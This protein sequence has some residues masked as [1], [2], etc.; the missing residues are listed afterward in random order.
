[1]ALHS[2]CNHV[3]PL[4]HCPLGARRHVQSSGPVTPAVHVQQAVCQGLWGTGGVV[5]LCIVGIL[6]TGMGGAIANCAVTTFQSVLKGQPQLARQ[7][8]SRSHTQHGEQAIQNPGSIRWPQAMHSSLQNAGSQAESS[9]EW[10]SLCT[11][12]TD[13]D[14]DDQSCQG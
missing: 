10:P 9:R 5:S 4:E 13:G 3:T 1:M 12:Q 8:W 11:C 14:G 6:A 2:P 7:D